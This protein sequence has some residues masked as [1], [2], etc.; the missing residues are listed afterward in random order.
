MEASLSR[1]HL[2]VGSMLE[3]HHLSVQG[4]VEILCTAAGCVSIWNRKVPS[5]SLANIPPF[6]SIILRDGLL[7]DEQV[8]STTKSPSCRATWTALAS[9]IVA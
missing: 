8:T 7:V 3:W 6:F 9:I 5:I 2:S 1:D 4:S